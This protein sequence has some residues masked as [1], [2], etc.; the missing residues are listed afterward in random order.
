MRE[1]RDEV[2]LAD[3]GGEGTKSGLLMRGCGE[4][5]GSMTVLHR[6]FSNKGSTNMSKRIV[7]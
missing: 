2:W 7:L 6:W 4:N 3:G 1:R 5:K